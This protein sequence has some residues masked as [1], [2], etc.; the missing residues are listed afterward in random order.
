MATDFSF[1]FRVGGIWHN[2]EE[3]SVA[4]GREPSD[5][6]YSCGGGSTFVAG[7]ETIYKSSYDNNS[8]GSFWFGRNPY[9][10]EQNKANKI[11]TFMF[12]E[13]LL[14]NNVK[15]CNTFGK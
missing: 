8:A 2:G 13:L 12:V 14:R 10:Y 5:F 7:Q 1:G 9:L 15:N 11:T 3:A 4:R 6:L